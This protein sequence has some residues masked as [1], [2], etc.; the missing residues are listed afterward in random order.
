MYC[1]NCLAPLSNGDTYCKVCGKPVEKNV[2]YPSNEEIIKAYNEPNQTSVFPGTKNVMVQPQP[3]PVQ[4]LEQTNIMA[5]LKDEIMVASP[6]APQMSSMQAPLESGVTNRPVTPTTNVQQTQPVTAVMPQAA[7]SVQQVV[8]KVTPTAPTAP[9]APVRPEPEPIVN[10]KGGVSKK[11]FA[12]GI[13]ISI[14]ATA[15]IACLICIPIISNKVNAAKNE[16][17]KDEPLIK[18]VVEERVLFSGY[19]FIIPEGYTHKISGTQL[20]VEKTDTKEAM[21]VQVANDTLA[22]IKVNLTTLKTNL[23]TAKWLIGK[24]YTDSAIKNRAY[25]TV[26][27]TSNNKKVMIGYTKANAKQVFGIVY[28]NPNDV[29]YPTTT[30]E[31]FNDIIDSAKEVPA[32]PTTNITTHT[33]KKVFFP[34]TA[35][36]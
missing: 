34:A 5:P 18:T 36:K 28:L 20:I 3:T 7:T 2:A 9:V 11:I 10:E 25:L 12:L 19:S 21:A 13:I 26:E 27:A 30:I 24:I 22:N 33:A 6:S 35:K 16:N 32:L 17:V 23:T 14:V 8:T 29:N 31:T 4:K 15:L 1:K